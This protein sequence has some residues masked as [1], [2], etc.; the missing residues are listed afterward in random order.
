MFN[1]Y[2]SGNG[3]GN[4]NFMDGFQQ[5][6]SQFA[7]SMNLLGQSMNGQ[8]NRADFNLNMGN[9]GTQM[10]LWASNLATNLTGQAPHGQ[11]SQT[12]NYTFNHNGM[13]EE[14]DYHD[15]RRNNNQNFWNNYGSQQRGNSRGRHSH[16]F[17]SNTQYDARTNQGFHNNN[18]Q[19]RSG[20]NRHHRENSEQHSYRPHQYPH[21]HSNSVNTDH[22]K[23]P[24]ANDNTKNTAKMT[25]DEVLK[26]QGNTL[27]RQ[28]QYAAAIE[29]YQAAI[30][31]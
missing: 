18:Q 24:R 23:A 2:G 16:P 30:V 17:T 22:S 27:F 10:G 11:Y 1:N 7:N 5:S 31:S 15:D 29:K 9:F 4:G 14:N 19:N 25:Q 12:N 21:Q 13:E 20:S 26:E 8:Q 6:M 3:N 28:K